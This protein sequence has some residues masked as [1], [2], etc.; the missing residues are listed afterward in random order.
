MCISKCAGS[1]DKA[2]NIRKEQ[3]SE[4]IL[5]CRVRNKYIASFRENVQNILA[6]NWVLQFGHP[7]DA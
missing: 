2:P 7:V 1:I 5:E 6:I 4:F 3:I